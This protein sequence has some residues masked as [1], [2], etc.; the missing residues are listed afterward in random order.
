MTRRFDWVLTAVA[1]V[2]MASFACDIFVDSYEPSPFLHLAIMVPLMRRIA[3]GYQRKCRGKH[4]RGDPR[5]SCTEEHG[6]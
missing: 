2:W 4:F 6:W 3:M 5:Q 1:V